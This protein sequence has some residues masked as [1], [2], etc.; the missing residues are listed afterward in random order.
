MDKSIIL[1]LI[2]NTAILLAFSMI[3]D[4]SWLPKKDS[5]K[6]SNKILAGV[7]IGTIGILLM[8]TPWKQYPGL[9]FDTRSVLL[10]LSG[11]FFGFIPSLI[12][13]VIMGI[14][15]I[16]LG[17][18]G[19][20]MGL[21]VI[22]LSASIGILWRKMRPGWRNKNYIAELIY[23]GIIVHL[24]MLACTFLLPGESIMPALRNIFIPILTIYP[25]GTVLL[26]ILMVRQL[27]NKENKD[28]VFRLIESERRF[29]D[30]LKN[31]NY[32]S[33][34]LDKSGNIM[35]CNSKVQE[36][37]GLTNE[38]L[39]GKNA[40]DTLLP[41]N[42]VTAVKDAFD[43][44]L[45][46][47]TGFYNYETEFRKY[48]GTIL[49]IEWNATV[50][51][52]NNNVVT[53]VA[54]IGQDI[55]NRKRAE[56][57]LINA[58]SKAEESD[59][60]KSIFL[61][62]MSHEIRTPMNA[63]MGFSSLIGMEDISDEEKKQYIKIIQNSGDRL[64]KIINDIIDISKLEAKQ[65][66]VNLTEC[67]IKEIFRE[68]VESFRKSDLLKEKKNVS[69]VTQPDN[70]NH[71]IIL[72][73]DRH[74]FQQILDNL[75][76][77]AIKYTEAGQVETGYRIVNENGTD[78][79]QV[80]V[81][82]TG[83]GIPE[84]M[85]KLIFE[86]FRQVDEKKYH[87]GA[88]LGLSITKGLID[89]L[90]GRIWFTSEP[91]KG[92]TFYFS[93][94]LMVSEKPKISGD[95]QN[96][97]IPDLTGKTVIVAEDDYNSFYYLRLLL[98][99]LNASVL[100]AE[101]GM[102]LMKLVRHKVPDLILLDINMPVKSGYECLREINEMGIKTRIIAQTAYSTFLEKESCIKA[103]CNGYIAKPVTKADLYREIRSVMI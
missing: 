62:N 16:F 92:T 42:T 72:K 67:S 75:I 80:Y 94:P 25:A 53:S 61:S 13:A 5:K 7:V 63:I 91:D 3:Y 87:E 95:Q 22:T 99:N 70:N 69:L 103:G 21:S 60:L 58:K 11:L 33:L 24:V 76:S 6:L 89:L 65:L 43:Y 93:I 30:L 32:F 83:I 38:E 86:R 71:D 96:S 35:F 44:I 68:S 20:W 15:R 98:K 84:D 77:N 55:T 54:T 29:I 82:D 26:G 51:R 2:Q 64:L 10:S 18:A 56:V 36:N 1:G 50:L 17:G 100:H 78:K 90:G 37:S 31:F 52:D 74:R 45:R 88:G 102:V 14:Y 73:T 81:K 23:L 66:S 46:G 85:S 101:N 57:E 4:Y 19:I 40:F 9:V 49:N 12:A 79:V 47:K 8:L 39:L 27:N 34:I 41:L 48:D 28:A 97:G 59:K